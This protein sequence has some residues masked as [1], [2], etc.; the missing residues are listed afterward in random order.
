L[1]RRKDKAWIGNT[2]ITLALFIGVWAMLAIDDSQASPGAA[3]SALTSPRQPEFTNPSCTYPSPIGGGRVISYT[4]DGL[5]RLTEAAYSTGECFL[6]DYDSVGNRELSISTTSLGG[7]ITDTYTYDD[8][9]RLTYVNSTPLTW[10]DNGNLLEDQ[11]GTEY[12][13]DAANR[14]ITVE[15]SNKTYEY[16]YNGFGDR[17]SQTVDGDVINYT[18][19]LVSSLTQVL[20]DGTGV[21]LY[22]LGR[23]GEKQGG[24]WLYH[25]TDALGSMR[26]LANT[27]DW[28]VLTQSFE[29]FGELL[30]S[31]GDAYSVYGY[32][33]EQ[34]DG[35]GLVYLRARYLDTGV[36]RFLTRDPKTGNKLQPETQNV[37]IYSLDN[38][39][40]LTDPTGLSACLDAYCY[41]RENPVTGYISWHGP[42][43]PP[44]P[45]GRY[46]FSQKY[47]WFDRQHMNTGNPSKIIEDVRNAISKG[48]DVITIKQGV[49]SIIE[50]LNMVF[51]ANY[52]IFSPAEI[53]DTKGI[54]LGIYMDWSMRFEMWESTVSVA[55]IGTAY[56]I[57][58]LPSHYLGFFSAASGTP[59][60]ELLIN[61]EVI[62]SEQEPPRSNWFGVMATTL[63]GCSDE[64]KKLKNFDF[65]P[66]IESDK[67]VWENINWPDY[68]RITPIGSNT[69]LWQFL[70]SDCEGTLCGITRP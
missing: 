22:G 2:L 42:G 70:D 31:E 25:L 5:G 65:T 47:G 15:Q 38:P 68:M 27:D 9:N 29:P 7:T 46:F 37:Y 34:V 3:P 30:E 12:N 61:L 20:D 23:I 4:Y 40:N 8:A 59:L 32:T 60:P 11:D 18:L 10:D 49:S 64:W 54:A 21:Y 50:V 24:E 14:L 1:W 39:I 56:A 66:R 45:E 26:Q 6:Y 57:E 55:G 19:D 58:D 48:G 51:S 36:G 53:K 52:E 67:D 62:P 69:G 43:K 35:S 28:I 41:W 16:A 13:Y 17:L 63:F 44:M 33:G